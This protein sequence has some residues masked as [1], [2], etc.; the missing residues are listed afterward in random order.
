MAPDPVTLGRTFLIVGA[1]SIGNRHL[2]NLR[3]LAPQS[4]IV[5]LRRE[6]V[7]DLAGTDRVVNSIAE[8][9]A[10]RPYA[11]IVA[12]PAPMHLAVAQQLA[13]EEQRLA[14]AIAQGRAP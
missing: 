6:S 4:R 3:Q 12:N 1:G 8:A 10:E 14:A 2:A 5:V 7:G 9:L 13:E 11:A